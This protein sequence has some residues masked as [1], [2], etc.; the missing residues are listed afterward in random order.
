MALAGDRDQL[1]RGR[2]DQPVGR[3]APIAANRPDRR[4]ASSYAKKPPFECPTSDEPLALSERVEARLP[5]H[6]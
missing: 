3:A 5:C 4:Q 2:V 1:D 6:L